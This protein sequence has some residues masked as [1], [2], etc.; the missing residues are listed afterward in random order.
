MTSGWSREA[1]NNCA[2]LGYYA[3]SSNNSFPIFL[4]N[5]SV[6][7]LGG[8]NFDPWKMGTTGCFVRQLRNCYYSLLNSPKVCSS[9]HSMTILHRAVSLYLWMNVQLNNNSWFKFSGC[10]C[11]IKVDNSSNYNPEHLRFI[12][13]WFVI[14]PWVATKALPRTIVAAVF[15]IVNGT[16]HNSWMYLL[17]ISITSYYLLSD[18]MSAESHYQL[19]APQS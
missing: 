12:R 15:I 1:D 13:L 2:L 18:R 10:I 16:S 17:P 19:P 7:S 14:Q 8:Q 5:L 9:C 3:V 11:T 6:P 4:D